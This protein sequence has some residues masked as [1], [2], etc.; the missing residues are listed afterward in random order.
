MTLSPLYL[1]GKPCVTGTHNE[2][3]KKLA[4]FCAFDRSNHDRTTALAFYSTVITKKENA[5]KVAL[6]RHLINE[7]LY[8][9]E[10]ESSLYL[11][12]AK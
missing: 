3:V 2:T 8:N 11:V 1:C 9:S 10:E 6:S 5:I 7:T 12:S 4:L